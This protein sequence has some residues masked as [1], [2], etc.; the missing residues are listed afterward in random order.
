M[1]DLLVRQI[2]ALPK[3]RGAWFYRPVWYWIGWRTFS[4]IHRGH[5]EYSRETIMLGWTFTG[6]IVIPLYYCGDLDCY[7]QTIRWNSDE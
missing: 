3:L 5:D 4:P 7:E 6:R 1:S 2:K